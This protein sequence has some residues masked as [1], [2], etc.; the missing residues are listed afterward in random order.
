VRKAVRTLLY[1]KRKICMFLRSL[2]MNIR[3]HNIFYLTVFNSLITASHSNFIWKIKHISFLLNTGPYQSR[4]IVTVC[5]AVYSGTGF[6]DA[7][8][9]YG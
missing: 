5:F 7:P 9:K 4:N 1:K 8:Q 3:I 2:W 6:V